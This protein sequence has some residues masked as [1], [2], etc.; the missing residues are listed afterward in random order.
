MF[1]FGASDKIVRIFYNTLSDGK[2]WGLKKNYNRKSRKIWNF[3]KLLISLGLTSLA[4]AL[5]SWITAL[6]RQCF[7]LLNEWIWINI[8]RNVYAINPHSHLWS[9]PTHL[10]EMRRQ[11][12]RFPFRPNHNL[13]LSGIVTK[14]K[15]RCMEVWLSHNSKINAFWTFCSS[16]PRN[17]L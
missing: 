4:T 9:K 11:L 10:D 14:K 5:S 3:F 13:T 16:F 1:L 8:Q 17:S 15:K 6:Q 7:G 2:T 12:F